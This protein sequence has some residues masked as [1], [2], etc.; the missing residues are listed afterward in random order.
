VTFGVRTVTGAVE[1]QGLV[2]HDSE[3]LLYRLHVPKGPGGVLAQYVPVGIA[4]EC[5]DHVNAADNVGF[6]VVKCRPCE[7]FV[8]VESGGQG[9]QRSVDG[10]ESVPFNSFLIALNLSRSAVIRQRRAPILRDSAA[11]SRSSA[12]VAFVMVESLS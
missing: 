3:H 9:S 11:L 8:S 7:L 10:H 1:Q 6:P 12:S 4:A 5:A 2:T